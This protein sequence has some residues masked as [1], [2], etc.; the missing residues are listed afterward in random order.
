M[1]V[2][3][4]VNFLP[5]VLPLAVTAYA[6]SVARRQKEEELLPRSCMASYYGR[7]SAGAFD[8]VFTL[9]VIGGMAYVLVVIFGL[10]IFTDQFPLLIGLAGLVYVLYFSLLESSPMQASLGK[11]LMNLQ[12]TDE[13]GIRIGF[14]RALARTLLSMLSD[15]GLIGHGLIFITKRRQGMHELLTDTMV[16]CRRTSQKDV[17][18]RS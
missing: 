15:V 13:N 8:Q 17:R 14:M 5:L 12:V 4:I 2:W 16:V 6:L 18:S 10:P 7:M 9:G 3:K 11:W 1:N